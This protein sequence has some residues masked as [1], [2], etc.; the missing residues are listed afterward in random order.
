MQNTALHLVNTAVAAGVPTT[1]AQDAARKRAARVPSPAAQVT[2]QRLALLSQT[3]THVL[4]DDQRRAYKLLAQVYPV[5]KTGSTKARACFISLNSSRLQAGM[6]ILLDPG[7]IREMAQAIEGFTLTASN[8]AGRFQ[9]N[10]VPDAAF[11][12]NRTIITAT[13]PLSPGRM[14]I[15]RTDYLFVT[16]ADTIP[17]AGLDLS[18]PYV[19][20][21][22][23]PAAAGMRVGV[24]L[25]PITPVGFPGSSLYQDVIVS[26]VG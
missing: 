9:M 26:K 19:D 21:V 5:G 8:V 4:T 18:Q 23:L 24:C 17:A 11:T 12:A 2:Q 15:A 14:E 6:S 22:G 13:R 3:Y 16:T 7:Q 25:T 1:P 20:A 10:V